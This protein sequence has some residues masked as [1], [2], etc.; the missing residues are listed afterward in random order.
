MRM[1]GDIVDFN[2][3]NA[4]TD[5]FEIKEKNNSSKCRKAWLKSF[6]FLK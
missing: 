1:V 5:L 4:T 2:A 3:A 6:Y